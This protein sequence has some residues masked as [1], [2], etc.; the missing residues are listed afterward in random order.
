MGLAT[1]VSQ[2]ETLCL[3]YGQNEFLLVRY[4]TGLIQMNDQA[5]FEISLNAALLFCCCFQRV[6]FFCFNI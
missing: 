1:R 3:K 4:W 2:W 6:I 5:V